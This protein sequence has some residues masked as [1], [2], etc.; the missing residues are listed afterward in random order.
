MS[1]FKSILMVTALAL[2]VP[3]LS[4][5]AEA[6]T[7]NE[8]RAGIQKMEDETLARLYAVRP[9][10]RSEIQNAVGYAVFSSGSL[11]IIYVSGGYGHGV[12]HDNRTGHNIYMEEATGGVGLGI[13]V[14]DARTIFVFH[15]A[16][17]FRDFIETGL[18]LSGNADAAAKQGAKGGAYA[19][20]ADVLKGVRVYQLTDTGLLAQ[21]MLQGT[22]YWVDSDLTETNQ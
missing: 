21:A 4:T 14:K 12:A 9:D 7:Q 22:K 20:S 17:A 1:A 18:D 19:G 3:V 15:D 5:C 16:G 6:S 13:G 8:K 11:A 2:T 10:T